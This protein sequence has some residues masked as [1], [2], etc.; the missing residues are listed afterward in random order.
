MTNDIHARAKDLMLDAAIGTLST[1]ET[2][3]L[4]RHLAEC[5]SCRAEQDNLAAS[6]GVFRS[7][8]V[9]A[10]PFLAARTRAGVRFRAEQLTS[11]EH[12]RRMISI[13]LGFDV[14]WTILSIWLMFNAAQWFGFA[15]ASWMWIAVVS[16]FWLLPGLGVLMIV[17]LR[18][19]MSAWQ[20]SLVMEG[21]SRE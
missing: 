3:E 10:P 12:R 4:M 15:T 1:A 21:D 19:G 20:Q 11:S 8:S 17:S 7:A 9:T 14:A 2:A 6:V 13:A 5:E 18:N 16:W